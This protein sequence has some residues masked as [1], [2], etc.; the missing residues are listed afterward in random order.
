MINVEK[1]FLV[2]LFS[3]A[4]IITKFLFFKKMVRVTLGWKLASET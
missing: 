2:G 1:A 4:L 3:E